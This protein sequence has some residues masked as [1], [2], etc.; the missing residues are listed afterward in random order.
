ME[1]AE[2]RELR[3]TE[4]QALQVEQLRPM[5]KTSRNAHRYIK[6]VRSYQRKNGLLAPVSTLRPTKIGIAPARTTGRKIG[7]YEKRYPQTFRLSSFAEIGSI[8]PPEEMEGEERI[9]N[10]ENQIIQI[11]PV[12]KTGCRVFF[13]VVA[14]AF[15]DDAASRGKQMDI[16]EARSKADKRLLYLFGRKYRMNEVIRAV[17]KLKEYPELQDMSLLKLLSLCKKDKQPVKKPETVAP[18]PRT[19]A[20]KQQKKKMCEYV[21]IEPPQLIPN[22]SLTAQDVID[23][24]SIGQNYMLSPAARL[25]IEC[26]KRC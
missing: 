5:P 6:L 8:L 26:L 19:E 12:P 22:A 20:V 1:Q 17:Y 14:Q 4:Y 16:V 13:D 18:T 7:K 9:I 25:E 24:R 3:I 11:K 21:I 2:I 10:G 15:I 23:I